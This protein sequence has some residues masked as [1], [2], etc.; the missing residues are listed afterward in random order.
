[1]V[2][3]AATLYCKPEVEFTSKI[4]SIEGKNILEVYIPPVEKK[5][6]YARDENKRWMAYIRIADESLLA[7]II[8]LRI[9]TG[10]GDLV[11]NGDFALIAAISHSHQK[12]SQC[13]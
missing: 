12:S 9:W 5:P 2:E 13:I 1:M 7:D 11:F 4:H 3:S 8:Q 10:E 6:V